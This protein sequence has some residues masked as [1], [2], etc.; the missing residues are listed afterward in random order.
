MSKVKYRCVPCNYSSFEIFSFQI[1]LSPHLLDVPN[2]VIREVQ[3]KDKSNT[4]ASQIV[5][6]GTF[7]LFKHPG[8]RS[9]TLIMLVNWT[10]VTLGMLF[11]YIFFILDKNVKSF[12]YFFHGENAFFY[13]TFRLLWH[14]HGFNKFK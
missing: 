8:C 7:D 12:W 5:E 9:I 14:W 2:D 4:E 10:S 6:L 1:T 13:F 11:S 3:G